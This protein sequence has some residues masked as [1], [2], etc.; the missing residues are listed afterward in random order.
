MKVNHRHTTALIALPHNRADITEEDSK[1]AH[2]AG[3]H[4]PYLVMATVITIDMLA[5][6]VIAT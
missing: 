5:S 1:L 2:F 4:G 3:Y 6:S